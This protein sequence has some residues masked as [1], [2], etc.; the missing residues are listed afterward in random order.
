M[1]NT[2]F[3][4]FTIRVKDPARFANELHERLVGLADDL[5]RVGMGNYQHQSIQS[6]LIIRRISEWMENYKD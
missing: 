5:E 1:D 2:F 4:S 6:S 3:D